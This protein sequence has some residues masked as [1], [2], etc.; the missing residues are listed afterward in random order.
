M[1]I[2]KYVKTSIL[3]CKTFMEM[4]FIYSVGNYEVTTL[5]EKSNGFIRK[6]EHCF[7]RSNKQCV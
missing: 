2:N 6:S 4:M 7:N 5:S 3:T 1:D